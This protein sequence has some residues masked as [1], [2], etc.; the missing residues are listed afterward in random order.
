MSQ[1]AYSTEGN[2]Q[3]TSFCENTKA[4]PGEETKQYRWG[5]WEVSSALHFYFSFK[6][7]REQKKKKKKKELEQIET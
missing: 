1:E 6:D 4:T 3:I 2:L 5:G 7:C